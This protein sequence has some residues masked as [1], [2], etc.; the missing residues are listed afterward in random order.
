MEEI[1]KVETAET[2][3]NAGMEVKT[4]ETKTAK[5]V[6][7]KTFTQKDVDAIVEKRLSRAKKEWENKTLKNEEKP[8]ESKKEVFEL[9]KQLAN[10][11][12]ELA[13]SR[14]PINEKFKDYVQFKV[15][16]N[17]NKDK[18]YAQA[19]DEF[20]ANEENKVFLANAENKKINTPRVLN[21]GNGDE[22]K[23]KAQAIRNSMG[24][25]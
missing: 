20:F 25:K 15:L 6:G 21:M 18:S 2:E 7:E 8:K 23:L 14:Y 24:L 17:V 22:T 5:A 10:Y 9:Q 4:S 11:E 12:K 19:I 16:R 13:L 1:Q 3:N